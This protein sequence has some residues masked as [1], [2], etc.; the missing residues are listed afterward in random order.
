MVKGDEGEGKR[1]RGWV[2]S[3][4]RANKLIY[5]LRVRTPP[6]PLIR[7]ASFIIGPG[8]ELKILFPQRDDSPLDS[9]CSRQ[10]QG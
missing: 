8:L 10:L 6:P 5:R 1:G 3:P 7:R 4:V 2:D 9:S